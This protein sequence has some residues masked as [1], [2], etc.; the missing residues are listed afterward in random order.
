[1][2][3][4]SQITAGLH[5][6][7]NQRFRLA[8]GVLVPELQRVPWASASAGASLAREVNV[9]PALKTALA[10]A[11]AVANP[12]QSQEAASLQMKGRVL[13]PAGQA[14]S[15]AEVLVLETG[16]AT[17]TDSSGRFGF[18]GIRPGHLTIR[19]RRPGFAPQSVGLEAREG[20]ELAPE[21]VLRPVAIPLPEIRALGRAEPWYSDFERRRKSGL[22]TS[23]G[24]EELAAKNVMHTVELLRGIPGVRVSLGPPGVTDLSY[25]AFSRCRESV[26]VWV[27]G[28][29]LRVGAGK[30]TPADVAEMLG[31]IGPNEV[32]A[33]EIF[34]GPAE[35]PA[36]FNND[37]CAAIAIW[38]K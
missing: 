17:T 24:P 10:L 14:V 4:K 13:G 19:I 27:N 9:N 8:Q 31:R 21:V 20:A 32:A 25:V 34:R 26:S 23:L 18:S 30:S 7:D 6:G 2:W 36:E 37:N 15:G 11:F 22:G 3:Q 38:T 29:Q 35:L 33:I 16:A 1:M 5:L 12:C 28:Q